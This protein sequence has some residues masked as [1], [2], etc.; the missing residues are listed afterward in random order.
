M[1]I[2][3][4]AELKPVI[5]AFHPSDTRRTIDI[6]SQTY[7]EYGCVIDLAFYDSDLLHLETAYPNKSWVLELDKVVGCIA[8]SLEN[9]KEASVHRL[10][11]DSAYRGHGFGSLLLKHVIDWASKH[12]L[13]VLSLW[14][15]VR[16]KHAHRLY[17]THGFELVDSRICDDLERS[18]EYQFKL[19]L[20]KHENRIY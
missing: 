8:L 4:M 5:R 18:R 16:F 9:P 7:K 2:K 1:A 14:S 13:S 3:L 6:V 20:R 19:D 12:Q 10:Y 17:H 11:L 15:D